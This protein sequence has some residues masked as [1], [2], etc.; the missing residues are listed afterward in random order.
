MTDLSLG[1]R[2]SGFGPFCVQ[3]REMSRGRRL[4][5]FALLNNSRV[6]DS[7]RRRVMDEGG[8]CLIGF[9]RKTDFRLA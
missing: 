8:I 2:Q 7:R 9:W 4:F 5:S 6:E 3:P 1:L